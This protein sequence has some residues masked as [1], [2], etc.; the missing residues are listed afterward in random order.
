MSSIHI[1]LE[2]EQL[3]RLEGV[4]THLR[5]SKS[6]VARN[7]LEAYVRE[8]EEDIEDYNDAIQILE[9]KN[10]SISWEELQRKCGLAD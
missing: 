9:K 6:Q 4:S 2:E 3:R 7:A 1:R 8:L 10:K 5:L